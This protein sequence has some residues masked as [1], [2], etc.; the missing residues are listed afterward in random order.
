MRLL[1]DDK[2]QR[3]NAIDALLSLLVLS[4]RVIFE[5]ALDSG[6]GDDTNQG[7]ELRIRFVCAGMLEELLDKLTEGDFGCSVQTRVKVRCIL[8]DLGGNR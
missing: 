2:I 6:F 8:H 7:D 3:G 4:E 1:L 5:E